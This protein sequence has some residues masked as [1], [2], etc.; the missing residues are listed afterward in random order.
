MKGTG[1]FLLGNVYFIFLQTYFIRDYYNARALAPCH[2]L[3][4]N[5]ITTL[6]YDNSITTEYTVNWQTNI[7]VIWVGQLR[8]ITNLWR[9][10]SVHFWKFLFEATQL[11]PENNITIIKCTIT[12]ILFLNWGLM[13]YFSIKSPTEG[14]CKTLF[15]FYFISFHNR[16]FFLPKKKSSKCNLFFFLRADQHTSVT[17]LPSHPVEF[18]C[19]PA[20]QDVH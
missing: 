3:D 5:Y 15:L 20:V 18:V 6:F 14:K 10:V 16:T 12:N 9:F 1:T 4:F 17:C 11:M 8:L 19:T 2:K 13:G 7:F